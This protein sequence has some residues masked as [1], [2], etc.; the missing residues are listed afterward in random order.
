M[1]PNSDLKQYYAD[2]AQE[3][4]R[5]YDIPERQADLHTLRTHLRQ[6][7]AGCDVL[8]VACGTGY[9]T[10][11]LSETARSI[12]A[13]DVNREVLDLAQRKSYPRDNVSFQVA[14]ALTLDGVS[15]EFTAGFAA[16]W[17]SHMKL[18]ELPGFLRVFHAKLGPGRLVVFTDN[19]LKGTRHPFTSRDA[20]GNMYQT[21]RLEDGREYEVLK[22]LPTEADLR[23][24]LAGIA[25]DINYTKLTY[26]WCLSYRVTYR[27]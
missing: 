15:G 1:N 21:R 16:F 20:E 13:T 10:Q 7:L 24:S 26:Y 14:D 3:Y 8:E 19:T 22:N 6:A 23:T 5:V 9:W 18:S 12:V 11:P 25:N 27:S 17:W 4:E 2:R